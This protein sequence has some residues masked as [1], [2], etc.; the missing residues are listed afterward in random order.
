VS[1]TTA[2]TAARDLV[3]TWTVE[4][5][6]G[7]FLTVKK[8]SGTE[9]MVS[10]T[11]RNALGQTVKQYTG[12]AT[13]RATSAATTF[14]Y[15]MDGRLWKETKPVPSGTYIFPNN[16]GVQ[17]YTEYFYDSAGRKFQVKTQ[18][19]TV[20][21]YAYD[22]LGRL[23][24]TTVDLDPAIPAGYESPSLGARQENEYTVT[25]L[26]HRSITGLAPGDTADQGRQIFTTYDWLRRPSVRTESDPVTGTVSTVG[27]EYSGSWCGDS[28]F[29]SSSFK[30]TLTKGPAIIGTAPARHEMYYN[31]LGWKVLDRVQYS[32]DGSTA[33]T[34]TGYNLLGHP[35]EVVSPDGIDGS[36]TLITLSETDVLGR[37]YK[38]TRP[39]GG[40]TETVYTPA[41]LVTQV[42]ETVKIPAGADQ[43]RITQT[44]YDMA[45]REAAVYPPRLSGLRIASKL[46]AY[47]SGG[48]GELY[49]TGSPAVVDAG[50]IT[51][52]KW[53]VAQTTYDNR[54][55]PVRV[56]KGLST[57]GIINGPSGF[58]VPD[59]QTITQA[60][61]NVPGQSD[62]TTLSTPTNISTLSSDTY[63]D[64]MDRPTRQV[65]PDLSETVT[66][67]DYAGR[68]VRVVGPAGA[69]VP[70]SKWEADDPMPDNASGTYMAEGTAICTATEYNA[71]GQAVTVGS[72]I[73]I[74]ANGASNIREAALSEQPWGSDALNVVTN[75]Y[76]TAGHLLTTTRGGVTESFTYDTAGNKTSV[77][78][79]KGESTL[80]T[81]DPLGRL[82]TT[83]IR[84]R[85]SGEEIKFDTTINT[86]NAGV[87][88]K[89]TAPDGRDKTMLYDAGLRISKITCGGTQS[90]LQPSDPDQTMV[91]TSAGEL[92]SVTFDGQPWRNTVYTYD[93]RGRKTSEISAGKKQTYTYNGLNQL[94]KVQ[95]DL[96]GAEEVNNSANDD[97]EVATE[98]DAMGRVSKITETALGTS[99]KTTKYGYDKMSRAVLKELPGTGL[100]EWKKY[101]LS[102][103]VT[104]QWTTR[105][106]DVAGQPRVVSSHVM[107]LSDA[108]G[109]LVFRREIRPAVSSI[110]AL[111]TDITTAN[112]YDGLNRLIMEKVWNTGS[113][114]TPVESTSWAYD[115]ANNRIGRDYTDHADSTKSFTEESDFEGIN[116]LI[117]QLGVTSAEDD[118]EFMNPTAADTARERKIPRIDQIRWTVRRNNLNAI[119]SAIGYRYDACGNRTRRLE[120]DMGGAGSQSRLVSSTLY[121]WDPSNRL[122]EVQLNKFVPAPTTVST[123][124]YRYDHRSRRI[125]RYETLAFATPSVEIDSYAG[126]TALTRWASGSTGMPDSSYNPNNIVRTAHFIRGS[127]FGG[128][129]GGLLYSVTPDVTVRNYVEYG[130]RGDV[131]GVTTVTFPLSSSSSGVPA[132]RADYRAFGNHKDFG[133]APAAIR[134]RAS[135]KEE[136]T[137]LGLLNE[138]FRY[139]DIQAGVFLSRD[140]AGF[141]DGPNLYTYV[142]QNPW[143]KFDPLGLYEEGDTW[144]YFKSLVSDAVSGFAEGTVV[145]AKN[146]LERSMVEGYE[147]GKEHGFGS[148]VVAGVSRAT[149]G[150]DFAESFNSHSIDYDQETGEFGTHEQTHEEKMIKRASGAFGMT[151]SALGGVQTLR[152]FT[153]QPGGLKM[154][155]GGAEASD[156]LGGGRTIYCFPAGTLV[157][158]AD[159]TTKVIEEVCAGDFVLADEPTDDAPT[160]ACR[161]GGLLHSRTKRLIHIAFDANGNGTEEG[162]LKATGQHPFWV[163]G[164]G[165][166]NAENLI[167]GDVLQDREQ[168]PISIVRVWQEEIECDTFNLNV[169]GIDTFFVVENGTSVLVH[170][171]EFD[172]VPY[173]PTSTPNFN[174]HGVMNA[175]LEANMRGVTDVSGAPAY[176]GRG[177]TKFPTIE[178]SP[179]AHARATRF[180]SDWRVDYRRANG[181]SRIDWTKVSAREINTLATGTLD[182]AGV[183]S[184]VQSSYFSKVNKWLN[185]PFCP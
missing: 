20:T 11:V 18:D 115:N 60:G 8:G 108:L 13:A 78:N 50:G 143:S 128:G 28:L 23:I 39:D 176:T 172:I 96:N 22:T 58:V 74:A 124:R 136:E 70:A 166:V 129:V 29:D 117:G 69:Q 82:L 105:M 98:Y 33:E 152:T 5:S 113:P 162:E 148:G 53:E 85:N 161:V 181:V 61:L 141:V 110:G 31:S 30:P 157:L 138:G 150:T 146:G 102:G 156:A 51:P 63:Y 111:A 171:S 112:A 64:C 54:G 94:V 76:D 168:Q 80:M 184:N 101:D 133:T 55:R 84:S 41:G 163:A 71:R 177:E 72:G 153:K 52:T 12:T 179:D 86:Y 62:Q 173:R 43:I 57:A 120:Y 119:V 100:R 169:E 48:N 183:P 122:V 174:H 75:T 16:N 99:G 59:Y 37:V 137:V 123:W 4:D 165:W 3:T 132:Y 34:R 40:I 114:A 83:M 160:K 167:S 175:W 91:S 107:L 67:Y 15:R 10:N 35:V 126:G 14:I 155:T 145:A 88:K 7:Q 49:R 151:M 109:N 106:P 131:N 103:R 140:P 118:T 32:P 9:S 135:T 36:T 24:T 130:S 125:V 158:M 159:G 68:A 2:D 182:V 1:L 127:D 19:G 154:K 17:A 45:G 185:T 90:A 26:L 93:I 116:T 73:K 139:R 97:L 147:V 104:D 27:M 65:A 21:E 6:Y 89:V 66:V 47:D 180:E 95:T 46:T 56:T 38:I 170:N 142:R 144:G 77:V 134:H 81:Y 79:G 121:L 42:T 178:L 92:L 164:R 44:D 25:G 87:L 149:G